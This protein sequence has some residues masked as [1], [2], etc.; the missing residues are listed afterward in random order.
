[1]VWTGSVPP[2]V[3][4]DYGLCFIISPG[5]GLNE[6]GEQR[7]VDVCFPWAAGPLGR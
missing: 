5:E 7:C 4:Q 1:M 6:L 3:I 2:Q